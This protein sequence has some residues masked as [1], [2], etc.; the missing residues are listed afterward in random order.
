MQRVDKALAGHFS[1]VGQ[2]AFYHVQEM[3]CDAD[4][5]G[6]NT[7][8][9]ELKV[10]DVFNDGDVVDVSGVSVGRGMAGPV[11]RHHMKGHPATRGT[12]EM[13]R[14]T[15]SVGMRKTPGRIFPNKRMPGH[16]GNANV[17]VQNLTVVGVK[18]ENNLILV[19]GGI[20][21]H[22][23]GLVVVRKAIKGYK[24]AKAA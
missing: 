9:K 7:P 8:G 20:P 18:P 22:K 24:G 2:G 14:C 19:K 3:R 15:G 11:K 6:W 21:G 1:K 4:A 17:T 13:Q 16:M 23:G 12:H 5:L 10:S